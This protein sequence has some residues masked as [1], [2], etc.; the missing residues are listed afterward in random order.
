MIEWVSRSSDETEAMAARVAALLEPGDLVTLRGALGTGKTC[1]VRGLAV[2]LG[3]DPAEVSSPT[4]VLVHEYRSK[5][6]FCNSEL[7]CKNRSASRRSHRL[8]TCATDHEATSKRGDENGE[9]STGITLVHVDAYRMSGPGELETIG[10]DELVG[11]SGI[12]LAIEWPERIGDSVPDDRCLDVNLEHID[13]TTR[14]ITFE[15]I[16]RV[17]DRDWSALFNDMT[18]KDD[19][20]GSVADAPTDR[21]SCPT[22][23]KPVEDECP[24]YPFC[25]ERC[26]LVDLGK[27]FDEKYRVPE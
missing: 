14:C 23:R 16:G 18:L 21:M 11:D 27:W 3:I 4:F 1:F 20:N 15:P 13:E 2:G 10:W 24:T 26:R 7:V 8:K 25:S 19:E 17:A 22:C 5:K 12:I 6:L 9:R